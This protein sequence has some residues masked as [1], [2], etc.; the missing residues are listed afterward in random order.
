MSGHT[1][2]NKR[3][4]GSPK[5]RHNP[6]RQRGPENRVGQTKNAG[7][8][9]TAR[10]SQASEK[11]PEATPEPNA[12]PEPQ[13]ED[14]APRVTTQPPAQT[15]NTRPDGSDDATA[16]EQPQAVSD[17]PSPDEAPTPAEHAENAHPRGRAPFAAAS[18]GGHAY[19]PASGSRQGMNGQS[20]HNGQNGHHYGNGFAPHERRTDAA[21]A[22]SE[23][24]GSE[25]D[26]T[27]TV[28]TNWRIDRL[29]GGADSTPREPFRPESRGEVGSLIDSLHEIFAQDRAVASQGES[30]RCGICY[31][32][33]P[34]AALEYREAEGFYVCAGCKRALGHN[35]LMMIRR[36]Q[37]PHIG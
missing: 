5:S 31:L 10:A 33:F 13:R 1:N 19:I 26:G 23:Y 34:L 9:A 15:M 32:H 16:R 12:E 20:G 14:T 18:R 25:T 8:P 22:M 7:P 29:N 24:D 17:A 35:P 37:P 36:Q 21:S 3:N 2:R 6:P 28:P 30:A 4:G 27:G 11:L